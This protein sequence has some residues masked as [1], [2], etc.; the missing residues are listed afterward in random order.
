MDYGHIL[1]SQLGYPD[2]P[3]ENLLRTSII[4]Q[5]GNKDNVK[6]ILTPHV[7]H[8]CKKLKQKVETLNKLLGCISQITKK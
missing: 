1:D 4:T 6:I 8:T 7:S 2:S 3:S 5:T